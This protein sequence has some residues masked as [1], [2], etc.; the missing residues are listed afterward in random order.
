MYNY[1]EYNVQVKEY[2]KMNGHLSQSLWTVCKSVRNAIKEK[3]IAD[4]WNVS[5]LKHKFLKR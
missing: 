1:K 4:K 3:K 5:W 2:K